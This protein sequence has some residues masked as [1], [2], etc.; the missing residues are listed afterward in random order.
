[1][2]VPKYEL[3]ESS[4]ESKGAKF[5]ATC[6]KQIYDQWITKSSHAVSTK[7]KAFISF[8]NKVT[9]NYIL[10]KLLVEEMCYAC[11]GNK[12]VN[13]GVNCETC[14]GLVI[15]GESI[16]VTHEKKYKPG[17]V[18]LKESKFC[19]K[20][21]ELQE[22]M[23]VY[24]DWQRSTAAKNSITCQKCHMIPREEQ[25][26]YHGF[27]T[28]VISKDIY[29]D[30]LAIDDIQIDYPELS[31]IVVNKMTGHA[32]PAGGPS[33][34]LVLA[35]SL[36]DEQGTE[37]YSVSESFAKKFKLMPIV[38]LMPYKLLENTQLQSEEIRQVKFT[39]PEF[40]KDK[41]KKAIITLKFYEM[42]GEHLGDIAQA[43]WESEP[44]VFKE[45]DL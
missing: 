22:A 32:V 31:L 3:A 40:F 23:T 26:S 38:G 16:A 18:L 24:S 14:H 41:A 12:E 43:Y 27:D 7:N 8:K 35:V 33:R 19:A 4:S 29:R 11:H 9:G 21:H 30:D 37:L 6:H 42:S 39:L 34:V 36:F 45:V 17:R 5:C 20:C 10:N 2:K 13:E 44:I 25:K 15:S 1:M 28:I